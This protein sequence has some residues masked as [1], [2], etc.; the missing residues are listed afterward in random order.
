LGTVVLLGVLAIAPSARATCG[1]ANCFLVT[2]TQEGV[3][4]SG[5]LTV[6]LSYRFISQSRKL[7]GTKEVSDVLVPKIDFENGLI[8]A[9]HHREIRTQNTLVQIDLSYG[10][11]PRLTLAGSLPIINQRDHEH[12]DDVGDPDEHFT[13]TDGSSGFGDVRLGARYALVVKTKDLLTGA[14][15][16]KLPTGAYTLHDSEGAINEPTIQPGTGTTDVILSAQ[17]AHQIVPARLEWFVAAAWRE[18][19]KNNLEYQFG[20]ESLVNTGFWHKTGDRVTWSLQ[21]NWRRTGRDEFLSQKISSTGVTFLDLTPGLRLETSAGTSLYG[22]VQ[23]PVRQ[24]VNEV[25]LAPRTA[26]LL[27]VSKSY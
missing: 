20:D 13:R 23:V 1:S 6:D 7:S 25:Q 14:V 4:A 5:I 27:G 16:I 9:D 8:L 12:W 10:L 2:G 11:T 26:L 22:F 17:Y 18:A 19:R 15:A 24:D 3:S 21:L